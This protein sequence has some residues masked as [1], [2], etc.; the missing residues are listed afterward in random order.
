MKTVHRAKI[1]DQGMAALERL[2]GCAVTG[3][4]AP[5]VCVDIGQGAVS[6]HQVLLRLTG[7]ASGFANVATEWIQTAF[8]DYHMIRLAHA[9]APEIVSVLIC[10]ERRCLSL[11]SNAPFD[12]PVSTKTENALSNPRHE[13]DGWACLFCD[14]W[15]RRNLDHGVHARI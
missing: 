15:D 12:T 2:R 9:N 14:L 8:E 4:L 10:C 5:R 6:A 7:Q 11:R 3:I 13:Q 1:D